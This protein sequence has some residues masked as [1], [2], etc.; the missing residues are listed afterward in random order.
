MIIYSLIIVFLSYRFYLCLF[1]VKT[2]RAAG[3]AG[4]YITGPNCQTRGRSDSVNVISKTEC[5]VR[6]DSNEGDDE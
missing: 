4:L 3:K 6:N 2:S 5:Q 1:Q